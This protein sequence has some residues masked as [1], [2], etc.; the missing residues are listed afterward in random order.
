ME[1]CDVAAASA[2]GA[3]GRRARARRRAISMVRARDQRSRARSTRRAR[4]GDARRRARRIARVDARRPENPKPPQ[5]F[6]K[7]KTGIRSARP[8]ARGNGTHRRLS[9]ALVLVL[10]RHCACVRRVFRGQESV[11][12]RIVRGRGARRYFPANQHRAVERT[13]HFRDRS[14]PERGTSQFDGF[15]SVSA[16]RFCRGLFLARARQAAIQGRFRDRIG[17]SRSNISLPVGHESAFVA[18]RGLPAWRGA[19]SPPRRT[20]R[21]TS[22]RKRRM[23]AMSM[24]FRAAVAAPA[25]LLAAKPTARAS[26]TA[27]V[28]PLRPMIRRSVRAPRGPRD[29]V[30]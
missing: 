6:T 16:N 27:K 30:D 2:T 22:H 12:R 23:A 3:R 18:F 28:R 13:V 7:N 29:S 14:K 19:R 17:Q 10:R 24:T 25:K 11:R 5:Q 9:L 4:R 1:K 26:A 15:A 20:P 8:R 21:L